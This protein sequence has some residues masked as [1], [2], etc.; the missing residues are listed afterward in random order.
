MLGTIRELM[1]RLLP[2]GKTA[3]T[4]FWL[5]L[6]ASAV[7]SILTFAAYGI[8]KGIAVSNGIKSGRKTRRI[9][10]RVLL[11]LSFMFG[12]FGAALGMTVFRHKIRKLKFKAGV[13]I[14]LVGWAAVCGLLYIRVKGG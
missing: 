3:E 4:V 5:F 6:A 2:N 11:W 13:P 12:S 14:M 1:F 9:P 8:D 10:E 7:M